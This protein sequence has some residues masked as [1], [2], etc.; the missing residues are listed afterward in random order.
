MPTSL[1][2]FW[3]EALGARA[4]SA[5]PAQQLE[6]LASAC[7]KLASDFGSWK[8]PWGEINRFQRIDGD[9]SPRFDDSQPSIPVP[10]TS[11]RWGSLAAFGARSYPNTKR[12]YG[13][14][15]NSFVA[16]VEFGDRLQARAVTA[17][18][19]SGQS[20]AAHFNDEAMRYAGGDLREV[21][22]YRSQLVGH[23]EREYHPGH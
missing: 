17:G 19:E 15:G 20:G 22:F 4:R 1:A 2:V 23:T 9:I 18:G 10:F 13:T 5:T 14:A 3:G 8:T 6:A 16:V 11:G 12:R 21:Y 7:D